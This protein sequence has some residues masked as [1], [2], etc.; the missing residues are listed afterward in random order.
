[1][2]R[3][4]VLIFVFCLVFTGC[5]ADDRKV[6]PQQ[7]QVEFKDETGVS[8]SGVWLSFSELAEMLNSEIG[9]ENEVSAAVDN[10][11]KL[12]IDNIYIH[13]RSHCDA[14]YKSDYFPLT[15]SAAMKNYDV[16]EYLITEFHKA[17][18]KV[19]AWINPYRVSTASADISAVREDSPI[20]KWLKDSDPANDR[21]VCVFEGVYLNPAEEE[22][23]RLVIDGVREIVNRYEVDGIHFD[24]YFYPTTEQSFDSA[25]YEEYKKNNTKPLRLADWRRTNVNSLLYGVKSALEYS[26]KEILFSISPAASIENN[27]NNLYAD[28][29]Y[30]VKNGYV[31]A[32]IP[33]LYFGFDYPDRN[34]RF[35]K[36]LNDWKRLASINGEVKLIIGLATYKIGTEALADGNEWLTQD[37]IIAR[38]AK[39][40]HDD[41][42]VSGYVMF[43][44]SS[45]V[46]TK[47]PNTRQ[48]ENLMKFKEETK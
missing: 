32:I 9:F 40:C 14:I 31:D 38:Q 25:S 48:R 17:D 1:M 22:V 41:E 46:S 30:W 10:C 18:I 20:H 12:K 27:Y 11:K 45:L 26:G 24:D 5:K 3:V 8:S 47:E 4:A 2:K 39:I 6:N 13:V 7:T 36:L 42:R 44:Y 37:D 19:H 16:L 34:F 35:E 28:V 15:A 33:Q 29:S 43:S 23:R 21:N